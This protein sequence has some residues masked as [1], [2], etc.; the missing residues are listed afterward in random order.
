VNRSAIIAAVVAIGSIVAITNT[1]DPYVVDGDTFRWHGETFRLH[2]IDAPEAR[3]VCYRSGV[4]WPCGQ[5][6]KHRLKELLRH[7][8]DCKRESFDVY[9]RTIA[10][11]KSK[12]FDIGEILV[13]EGLA[14]AFTRYSNRYVSI[15]ARASETGVGIWAGE[16]DPP[17]AWRK[18]RLR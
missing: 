15:E 6:S 2:G 5:V 14:L 8:V 13:A 10:T 7:G 9:G 3:Q 17:K 11:C 18:G 1:S 16:F 4:S 12:G